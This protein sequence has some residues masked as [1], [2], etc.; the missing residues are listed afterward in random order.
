MGGALGYQFR[1][2][3]LIVKFFAGAEAEDQ[4]IS[5]RDPDNAVQGSAVGLKLVVDS[6]LD[7]SPLWL[8]SADAA[9]GT[10]FQQY[11]SLARRA[12]F[13]TASFARARRR[14]AGNEEYDAGRGGGFVRADLRAVELT[15]SGGFTGNYLEDEPSGYVSLAFRD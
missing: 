1:A 3:T 14:S 6:W 2:D 15:L 7:V 10:A 11:W 13:W 4:R 8:L 5:P 9:Y 12:A